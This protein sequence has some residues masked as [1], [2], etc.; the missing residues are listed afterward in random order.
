[1]VQISYT[2]RDG[3]GLLPNCSLSNQ[4]MTRCKE[5]HVHSPHKSGNRAFSALSCCLHSGTSQKIMGE[6][7]SIAVCIDVKIKKVR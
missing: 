4:T 7:R 1:M 3:S 2:S 6:S 5:V